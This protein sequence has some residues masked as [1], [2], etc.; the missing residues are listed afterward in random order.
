M[1]AREF[2]RCLEN[3]FGEY[4]SGMRLLVEDWAAGREGHYLDVLMQEISRSHDAGY[5]PTLARL[6][7]EAASMGERWRYPVLAAPNMSEVERKQ[8]HAWLLALLEDLKKVKVMPK[9]KEE[10]K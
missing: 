10:K 9:P 8:A 7:K 6:I 3:V 5:P 4:R 1:T 2:V